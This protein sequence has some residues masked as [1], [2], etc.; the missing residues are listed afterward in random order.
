[1]YTCTLHKTKK[2]VVPDFYG[3]YVTLLLIEKKWEE[4]FLKIELVQF[5]VNGIKKVFKKDVKF[6]TNRKIVIVFWQRAFGFSQNLRLVAKKQSQFSCLVEHFTSFR[7]S[8]FL[9]SGFC[10]ELNKIKNIVLPKKV[11]W[12]DKKKIKQ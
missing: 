6:S 8:S 4:N 12:D 1:M 7:N 5:I 11:L 3:L 9:D 10:V 2:I